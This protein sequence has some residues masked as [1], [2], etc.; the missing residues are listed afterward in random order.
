VGV[1]PRDR[2]RRKLTTQPSVKGDL[3]WAPNSQK[4]AFTGNNRL[5]EVDV[6]GGAVRE[7]A[8]NQAGGYTMVG[9]Y[10]ADGNW[11]TYTKRDD[12]QNADVFVFDVRVAARGER[13]AQSVQ[14]RQRRDDAG[15]QARGVHVEPGQWVTQ[16]FAVSLAKLTEDPN[17]PLV[18][19]RM[20]RARWPRGRGTQLRYPGAGAASAAAAAAADL[21]VTID[22][23]GIDGR[24]MQLTRG[25]QAVG[26][27]FLSRDGRTVYFTVGGGGG[28]GG[29]GQRRPCPE[30]QRGLF[31]MNVDGTNRRRIAGGLFPGSSRPPPTGA[32]CS[33]VA[34]HRGGDGEGG[35]AQRGFEISAGHLATPQRAGAVNFSFP[36]RW[37]AVPSGGSCSRKSW[38]VMKYRFYDEKMHGRTGTRS[39]QQ[40]KPL[41][42]ARGT[43][44]DVYDLANEMIGELNASHTGVSGPPS[45]DAA[46]VHHALPGL[47]A[48][49]E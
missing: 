43:N 48:G 10:S 16:L 17:D 2:R 49:A 30:P 3:T 5:W 33:S 29:G 11:L 36:V 35:R 19:E 26:E 40:Y 6:S 42:S 7:L 12:D 23:D 28:F 31:A 1:R 20:R 9:Q 15:R 4:L 8:Y 39:R 46:R 21:T 44:E 45:R 32:R 22:A 34:R 38:R 14:R 24:A 13:H 27:L 41:L 25:A 47:R 37:T 18:R